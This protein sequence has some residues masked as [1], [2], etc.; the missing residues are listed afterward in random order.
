M[1]AIALVGLSLLIHTRAEAKALRIGWIADG[2]WPMQEEVCAT[3]EREIS[4][5]MTDVEVSFPAKIV[6][7]WSVAGV[8]EAS[9]RMLADPEIDLVLAMGVIASNELARRETLPKPV[10]APWIIDATLQGV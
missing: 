4:G 5:L 2:P 1:R 3:F 9:D 6:A 10:V 7:D 8:R